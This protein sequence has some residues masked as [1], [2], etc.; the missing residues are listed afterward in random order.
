LLGVLA[1]GPVVRALGA[2]ALGDQVAVVA[3]EQVE[4][5]GDDVVEAAP[6]SHATSSYT[7]RWAAAARS[8]VSSE[9]ARRA[10]ARA[11]SSA[12]TAV[13]SAPTS[14]AGT[15]RPA[16]YARTGS[17]SPPTSYTTAGTPAPSARR[18]AP[19]WSISARYG[20]T[21][22]VASPSA[23]SSSRSGR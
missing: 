14:P 6:A 19:D 2:L 8:Q 5:P 10:P 13:V 17:A 4:L 16:P 12:A 9:R 22:M 20:K 3:L 11:A 21:A 1:A 23:R 7:M 15:T 18:S